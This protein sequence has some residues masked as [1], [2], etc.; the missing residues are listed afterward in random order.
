MLNPSIR[1]KFNRFTLVNKTH[2][3]RATIETSHG[4]IEYYRVIPEKGRIKN[5]I[6]DIPVSEKESQK[7][8]D[9]VGDCQASRG[10]ACFRK[11]EG[12]IPVKRLKVFEK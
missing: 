3:E 4:N 8:R 7:K 1:N 9:L 11:T 5:Y 6:N 12:G 10:L 2:Q